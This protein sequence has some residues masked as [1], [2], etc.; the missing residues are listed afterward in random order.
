M[1][2]HTEKL[3]EIADQ[4][5]ALMVRQYPDR[6]RQVILFGSVAMDR[7]SADSDVDLCVV[8]PTC[9]DLRY[10]EFQFELGK[11]LRGNGISV[12]ESAGEVQLTCLSEL[13]IRQNDEFCDLMYPFIENIRRGRV[14][15][16]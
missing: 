14:L 2:S 16:G 9:R 3:R 1:L 7:A 11:Y 5:T 13:Q 15:Y 6:I 10:L 4:A 12:G 8:V